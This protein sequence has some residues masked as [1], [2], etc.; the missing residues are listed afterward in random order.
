VSVKER[1][2]ESSVYPRCYWS[3]L[4]SGQSGRMSA[5]EGLAELYLDV[6]PND[7]E[8]LLNVEVVINGRM[9]RLHQLR[10]PCDHLTQRGAVIVA[11]RWLRELAARNGRR[12]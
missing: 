2:T 7:G 11:R 10:S 8:Q 12:V 1:R 4:Y 5:P 3:D 6:R 9:H